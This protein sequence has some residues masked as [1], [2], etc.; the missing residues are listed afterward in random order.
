ML[1]KINKASKVPPDGNP[2]I[3]GALSGGRVINLQA[4]ARDKRESRM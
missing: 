3:H 2:A 1:S 4:N